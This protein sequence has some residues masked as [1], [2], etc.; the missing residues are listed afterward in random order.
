MSLANSYYSG[1]GMYGNTDFKWVQFVRDHYLVIRDNYCARREIDSTEMYNYRFRMEEWLE[2][3]KIPQSAMW[4]ILM[5]NQ[6]KSPLEFDK[7]THILIPD[8]SSLASL[9]EIYRSTEA[10]KSKNAI[11][12]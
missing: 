6:M 4:L 8:F 3:N 12:E 7:L 10:T 9:Y 11:T 1:S 5:L 2:L